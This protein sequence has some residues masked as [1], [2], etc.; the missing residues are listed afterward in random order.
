MNELIHSKASSPLIDLGGTGISE[1]ARAVPWEFRLLH[2]VGVLMTIPV[3]AF[4]RMLAGRSREIPEESVFAE[5]NCK[6]L[7]AL[8]IAFME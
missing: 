3:I 1:F 6:V 5:A 4:K 2:V 8:G 7:T